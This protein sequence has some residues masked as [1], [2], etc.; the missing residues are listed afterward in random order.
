MTKKQCYAAANIAMRVCR[1]NEWQIC[2][3][4]YCRRLPEIYCD[5]LLIGP[6]LLMKAS[7]DWLIKPLSLP[8]LVRLFQENVAD[9]PKLSARP[10]YI[11]SPEQ[12]G[13]WEKSWPSVFCVRDNVR[14]KLNNRLE[15]FAPS[16][17]RHSPVPAR[18]SGFH[19]LWINPKGPCSKRKL[20]L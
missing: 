16:G 20:G 18:G 4:A 11:K 5:A 8:S 6:H 15:A 3:Q 19:N 7:I 12:Q 14:I 17:P 13:G 9:F 1:Q 2:I 10:Q